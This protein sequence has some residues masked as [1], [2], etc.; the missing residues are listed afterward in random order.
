[1]EFILMTSPPNLKSL[2][3]ISAEGHKPCRFRR[4]ILNILTY[5][6]YYKQKMLENQQSN[7]DNHLTTMDFFPIS[8]YFCK[9]NIFPIFFYGKLPY[10]LCI[11]Q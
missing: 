3:L 6:I 8:P 4:P 11:S 10:F 2:L 7:M 5:H 1:M 9:T